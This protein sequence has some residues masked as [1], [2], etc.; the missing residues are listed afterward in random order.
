MAIRYGVDAI[1]KARVAVVAEFPGLE[2]RLL[3]IFDGRCGFCNWAVRWF[4]KRDGFDR[5]RFAPSE[6]P[7]VAA[8]LRRHG[9]DAVAPNT[10]I[11]VKHAGQANEK[12]LVRS[13]GV[14]EML[15]S[16]PKSWPSLAMALRAF[17][18][19]VRDFGYRL[20][21]AVRY[22]LAGRYASCPV[23]TAEER[24]RFLLD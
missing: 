6:S 23:P 14:L 4:L 11:V 16:L 15:G 8:L 3:V 1:E 17:P 21:A 2:R 22:R 7:A 24:G 10:L 20:A 9:L 13:Q 12:V 18:P 5:F 19:V